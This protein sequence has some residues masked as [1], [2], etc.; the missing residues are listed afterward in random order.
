MLL[1]PYF[2]L[3][4]FLLH[5]KTYTELAVTTF[6]TATPIG[7]NISTLVSINVPIE[8]GLNPKSITRF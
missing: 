4:L 3:N 2:T 1:K 8:R 5:V 6:E 7:N